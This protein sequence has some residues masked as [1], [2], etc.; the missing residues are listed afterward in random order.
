MRKKY[1]T[2]FSLTRSVVH[3]LCL[4]VIICEPRGF[5]A[6]Q[7]TRKCEKISIPLCQ[8]VGYN[9]T[10]MP[11][12]YGQK[13]QVEAGRIIREFWPLVLINC[14]NYLKNFVCSIYVPMCD[15]LFNKEVVP[16]RSFCEDVRDS[17]EPV[18]LRNGYNWP[19]H[20]KC[21]KFPTSEENSVCMKP[22][23]DPPKPS[24]KTNK[25]T[26]PNTEKNMT[27]KEK[28]TLVIQPKEVFQGTDFSST[29]CGCLCKYPF[30]GVN[31][32]S[33]TDLLPP[34]VLPCG[35]YFFTN[36]QN[37]FMKFWLGLWSILSFITTAI[38]LLTFVIDR[39]R[40]AFI[41]RPII[42]ISF[43]YF[44]VSFGYIMRL[45]YGYKAIACNDH[46]GFMHYAATGPVSCTAVFILTYFFTNVS[47]IWWVVLSINWFLSSGLKWSNDTISSY[48]Q[49]FH[50]VAWL[51]PTIQTMAILAMSAID[52]DPV[53]GLCSVGN[54]D[55][56]TLT[57]FVIGPLLIYTMLSLSFFIAGIMAKLKIDNIT[58]N[59]ARNS[60]KPRRFLSRVG[61]FTF[62]LFVPAVSLLGCYFYEHSNKEIWEK[63]VNCECIQGKKRP[64]FYAF[65]LKYLMS[66]VVGV[67]I[68]LWILNTTTLKAWGSFFKKPCTSKNTLVKE[69]ISFLTSNNSKKT[70]VAL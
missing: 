39:T 25:N 47:W 14:S 54:H 65:L 36:T 29:E 38:T 35:Q 23:S 69:K 18:M 10:F 24:V 43:C 21:S 51:I 5:R 68:G 2:G 1:T 52:G 6:R 63:S 8:E 3:L 58:Q 20:L 28:S 50:F 27:P 64:I 7:E 46:T 17:C 30:V 55:S 11:N 16:C 61:L 59:D 15:P 31:T 48:S 56:N 12:E 66:L 42:L 60:L 34:C 70:G 13:N 26:Y 32:S 57:I 40:F 33:T 62:I 9:L 41:E 49:Y 53:S 44:V 19:D 37:T 67:I 22:D 4:N 45:I